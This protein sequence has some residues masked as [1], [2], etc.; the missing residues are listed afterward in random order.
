LWYGIVVV[1]GAFEGIE[2]E[3]VPVVAVEPEDY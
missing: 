1:I 2:V 3:L